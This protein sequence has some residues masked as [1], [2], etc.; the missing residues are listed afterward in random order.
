MKKMVNFCLCLVFLLG[1]G[2]GGQSKPSAT[3]PPLSSAA[4]RA[5]GLCAFEVPDGWNIQEFPGLKHR[6]V[7]GQ[8]S[9]GFAPNLNVV[10]ENNSMSLKDYL[11]GNQ[12]TLQKVMSGYTEDSAAEFST[13]GGLP[14]YRLSYSAQQQNRSLHLVQYLFDG[15]PGKKIV[16]TFTRLASQDAG[17]DALVD[18][19]LK[20]FRLE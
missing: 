1:A 16:V 13:A 18:G 7:A 10:D 11:A 8:P 6:I 4:Y 9:N 15:K 5:E 2:C 20:S 12:A 17:L 14:A 3:A 19:K